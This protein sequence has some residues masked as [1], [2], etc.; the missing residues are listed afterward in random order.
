MSEE[1]LKILPSFLRAGQCLARFLLNQTFI[2]FSVVA[3]WLPDPILTGEVNLAVVIELVG[4]EPWWNRTTNLLIK[5]R[6]FW[7]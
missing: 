6:V 1:N 7:N 4:Y 3:M 2:P 5:R